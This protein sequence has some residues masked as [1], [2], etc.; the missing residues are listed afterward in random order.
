[1]LLHNTLL[2]LPQKLQKIEHSADYRSQQ[3]KVTSNECHTEVKQQ[4]SGTVISSQ[5]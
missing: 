4:K 2:A 5:L 1:M 3:L